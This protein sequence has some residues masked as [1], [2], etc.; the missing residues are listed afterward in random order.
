MSGPVSEA[1]SSRIGRRNVTFLV[2]L[3]VPSAGHYNLHNHREKNGDS[4][5]WI[6]LSVICL[7][8]GQTA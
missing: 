3:R 4:T 2:E 1:G 5:H 8:D 6:Y 7:S